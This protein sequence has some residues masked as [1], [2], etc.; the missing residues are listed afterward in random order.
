MEEP[1]MGRSTIPAGRRIGRRGCVRMVS[2]ID[3]RLFQV[4]IARIHRGHP[5]CDDFR[6]GASFDDWRRAG[7]WDDRTAER[8]VWI[9]LFHPRGA[10]C[11][12][13][14][15][16]SRARIYARHS[17]HRGRHDASDRLAGLLATRGRERF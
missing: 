8:C 11:T 16:A 3:N 9:R 7:A 17:P 1:T 2:H 14:R 4:A 5:L 12:G 6:F 10:V 13:G 15:M